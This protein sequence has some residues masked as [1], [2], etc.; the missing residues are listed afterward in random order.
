[1]I[2]IKAAVS[3]FEKS[4]AL[5][6]QSTEAYRA[7]L[8]SIRQYAVEI[9]TEACTGHRHN[10]ST[11]EARL[12]D[13]TV[14][15][16]IGETSTAL[17]AELR[18]YRDKSIAR[19]EHLKTELKNNARL[20]ENLTV[21]MA[22][23][24]GDHGARLAAELKQLHRVADSSADPQLRVALRAAANSLQHCVE[25]MQEQHRMQL[26][27]MVAEIQILHRRVEHLQSGQQ[28]GAHVLSRG[29]IESRLEAAITD[30]RKFSVIL[31]RLRNLRAATAD[32]GPEL[33]EAV[34][35][36][37]VKRLRNRIG[38]DVPLGQ[39]SDEEVLAVLPAPKAEAMSRCKD[40]MPAL[41]G[42]YSFA[43]AGS[44]R[45][46]ALQVE[47]GVAEFGA[48]DGMRKALATVG[49]LLP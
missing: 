42:A 3:D 34:R 15:A 7:A 13:A 24:D 46:V 14:P 10:L 43:D 4:E 30:G 21:A 16:V 2:S 45:R 32:S 49:K 36:A 40:L 37:F 33:G 31:F 48:G 29:Q 8:A 12:G 9:E 28:G 11:I 47:T 17:R 5:R 18:D 44:T 1:M 25:Q 27:Q 39:W 22:E 41:S 38:P 19:L 23:S 35:E 26:A 20:L 6:I